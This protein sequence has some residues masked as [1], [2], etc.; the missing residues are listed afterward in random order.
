MIPIADGGAD[1]SSA[2]VPTSD[3]DLLIRSPRRR[4]RAGTAAVEAERFAGLEVDH[5]FVLGRRLHRQVGRFLAFEDAIDVAG[6]RAEN[7]STSRARKRSGRRWST[8][9][10]RVDRGQ[11]VL[12]C[13]RRIKSRCAIAPLAP[14]SRSGR[15]LEHAS[16]ATRV[17]SI[18]PASR[19]L[20]GTHLDS[21]RRR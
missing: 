8:K 20:I 2:F 14:M 17:R 7:W 11:S 10:R 3:I 4:G 21:N 15:G 16:K 6:A 9:A 13:Q 18:S 5:E 1:P 19:T 12:S